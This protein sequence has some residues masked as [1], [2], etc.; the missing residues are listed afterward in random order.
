MSA[1]SQDKGEGEDEAMERHLGKI[2]LL[3]FHLAKDSMFIPHDGSSMVIIYDIQIYL[4]SQVG[5]L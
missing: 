4:T 5:I 3:S 2:F 1:A